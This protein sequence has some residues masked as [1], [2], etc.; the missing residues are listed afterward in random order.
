MNYKFENHDEYIKWCEQMVHG[1]GL[2]AIMADT[3]KVRTLVDE[4]QV[5]LHC[6]EGWE[7]WNE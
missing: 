4:I 7:L 1:I 2:A 3:D 6:S 5:T